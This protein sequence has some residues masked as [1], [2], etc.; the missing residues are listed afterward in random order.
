MKRIWAGGLT[1]LAAAGWYWSAADREPTPP[2]PTAESRVLS[3]GAALTSRAGTPDATPRLDIPPDRA[4][5]QAE[6]LA[7]DEYRRLFQ[8]SDAIREF[9]DTRDALTESER[10]IRQVELQRQLNRLEDE[11]KVTMTEAL[12]L[13]LA[14]VDDDDDQ[15]KAESLVLIERYERERQARLAAYRNNPDPEFRSY[16]TLEAEIIREIMAMDRFP[17]GLTRDEY[18]AQRLAEARQNAYAR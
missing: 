13:R 18:L 9:M 5:A 2:V 16:K 4:K 8:L 14:L 1:I 6:F 17:N 12:A 15:A 11:N 7:Y 10:S 3:S